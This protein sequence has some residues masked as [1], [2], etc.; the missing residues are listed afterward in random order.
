[1]AT[2]RKEEIE[3]EEDSYSLTTLMQMKKVKEK[4]KS[5][6]RK[7]KMAT[8]RKEEI[9]TLRAVTIDSRA[10]VAIALGALGEM[11]AAASAAVTGTGIPGSQVL[12]DSHSS[13]NSGIGD[14]RKRCTQQGRCK[15]ISFFKQVV[16]YKA[17]HSR[18][19]QI[20]ISLYSFSSLPTGGFHTE[21]A[22]STK[23]AVHQPPNG[24]RQPRAPSNS[25]TCS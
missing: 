22:Q 9:K 4:W 3:G 23:A 17:L 7:K 10:F 8:G 19:K 12:L 21:S 16:T 25:L 6:L 13:N 24:N 5:S 2:G 14:C 20:L 15:H 11:I 1:M 18:S